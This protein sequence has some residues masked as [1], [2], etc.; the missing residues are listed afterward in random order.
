MSFLRVQSRVLRTAGGK[1]G[2]S[3]ILLSACNRG[4]PESC[5]NSF[6]SCS[7]VEGHLAL[8]DGHLSLLVGHGGLLL[9]RVARCP[10]LAHAL[11]P[12][13]QLGSGGTKLLAQTTDL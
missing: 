1:L 2:K 7:F 3:A 12:R 11:L 9:P 13:V 10:R 6:C 8:L 5:S 4:P